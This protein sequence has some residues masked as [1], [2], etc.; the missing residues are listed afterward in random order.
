MRYN[1]NIKQTASVEFIRNT[2]ETL[3]SPNHLYERNDISPIYVT[4]N[5][6]K[7][8]IK[9]TES[10]GSVRLTLNLDRIKIELVGHDAEKCLKEIN[11]MLDKVM[12]I[13]NHLEDFLSDRI[14]G[15]LS[16]EFTQNAVVSKLLST[17]GQIYENYRTNRVSIENKHIVELEKGSVENQLDITAVKKNVSKLLFNIDK[18]EIKHAVIHVKGI[19][20]DEAK[21]ITDLITQELQQAEVHTVFSKSDVQTHTIVEGIFFGD[22]EPEDFEDE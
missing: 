15:V 21:K 16:E 4:F 8:D 6:Q 2:S 7:N 17:Y 19:T 3:I 14:E 12:H 11:K 9:L 5:M 10:K 13:T 22:F 20:N 1:H 18:N